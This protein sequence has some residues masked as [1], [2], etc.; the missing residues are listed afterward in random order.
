MLCGK[1]LRNERRRRPAL[2]QGEKLMF[3]ATT[4]EPSEGL[5]YWIVVEYP[6]FKIKAYGPRPHNHEGFC[7]AQGKVCVRDMEK[8]TQP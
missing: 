6:A 7:L 1:S 3:V 5:F 4:I 8:A 2:Q